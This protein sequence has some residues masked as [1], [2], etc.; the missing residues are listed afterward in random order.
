MADPLRDRIAAALVEAAHNCLQTENCQDCPNGPYVSAMAGGRVTEITGSPEDL[1][2]A[3]LAMFVDQ[4]E[5]W[6]SKIEVVAATGPLKRTNRIN[7]RRYVLTTNWEDAEPE[8]GETSCPARVSTSSSPAPAPGRTS[9][10]S[11]ATSPIS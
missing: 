3:V 6:A 10:S 5:E 11:G 7:V 2:D 4:E 9:S 1:A 8:A